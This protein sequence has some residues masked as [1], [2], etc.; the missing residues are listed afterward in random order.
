MALWDTSLPSSEASQE[1]C[2]LWPAGPRS[3][4]FLVR[5]GQ[6]LVTLVLRL[7]ASKFPEAALAATWQVEQGIDIWE[8]R[9]SIP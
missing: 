4:N 8:L 6:L 2:C 5:P 7:F 1:P 3:G 9:G